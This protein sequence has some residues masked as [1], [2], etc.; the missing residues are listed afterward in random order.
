MKTWA[1]KKKL[2]PKNTIDPPSAKRN[3]DGELVTN[4]EELEKLYLDTYV[5]RLTPNPVKKDLEDIVKLKETLFAMR[6]ESSKYEVTEDWT[7][8]ALEKVLKSLKNNKARDAHGHVYELFKFGGQDLKFSL[9]KM[10]NIMKKK[11]VYPDIFRPSNI[12]SFWKN[13]GSKEELSSQRGVFNKDHPGK[14]DYE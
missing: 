14:A 5:E 8:D 11:Q 10:F 4:K 1:L 7:M 13:R 9:L 6:I 12:S 3:A 2:A